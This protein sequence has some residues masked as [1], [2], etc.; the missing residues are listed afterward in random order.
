MQQ[1]HF[2]YT[3]SGFGVH[4]D[5]FAAGW[6]EACPEAEDQA[7]AENESVRRPRDRLSPAR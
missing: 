2:Q 3:R 5:V 6:D 1:V 7:A 4:L